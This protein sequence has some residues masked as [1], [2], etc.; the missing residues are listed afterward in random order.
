M[1]EKTRNNNSS[2]K[3]LQYI[4]ADPYD[5]RD[6]L[7]TQY[8]F[9]RDDFNQWFDRALT[10][11]GLDNNPQTARWKVL[12]AG[13]GEG[14]FT[15]EVLKRYPSCEIVG[16]D[17]DREAISTA[18]RTF[19]TKPNLRFFTHDAREPIPPSYYSSVIGLNPP[20]ASSGEAEGFDVIFAHL[21]V[22]HIKEADR[23]MANLV[24]ALKPGGV[25]YL[26]DIVVEGV[27]FNNASWQR[28]VEV[29][30]KAMQLLTNTNFALE[31]ADYFRRAGLIP[32]ESGMTIYPIG[33]PTSLGQQVLANQI[34]GYRAA[35]S[36]LVEHLQM[37]SAE[38]FDEHMRHISKELT[39][40]M[41]GEWKLIN[42][43]A[44]KPE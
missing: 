28:L 4:I 32:L 36:G 34:S 9:F 18:S 44:R 20:K 39:P 11:A 23:A 21:V 14:L 38:E 41:E 42:S 13:C 40:E 6:R 25:I 35:R 2:K 15:V 31:H 19:A 5:D 1:T 16:F 8:T 43:I 37:I 7:F 10:L 33:G 17:R 22:M 26:R 12:D 3:S 30:I 29:V 27:N 24:A